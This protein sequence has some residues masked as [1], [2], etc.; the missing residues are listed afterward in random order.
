MTVTG[1]G[2]STSIDPSDYDQ[3]NNVVYAPVGD[4]IACEI[5]FDSG[6]LL[7]EIVHAHGV[8]PFIGTSRQGQLMI[9]TTSNS[10]VLPTLGLIIYP[11]T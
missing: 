8:L 7:V 1:A 10:E 3:A 9:L 4:T 6:T 2:G 5:R 11:I